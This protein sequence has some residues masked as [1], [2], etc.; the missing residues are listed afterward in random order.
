MAVATEE[1]DYGS[2]LRR[3]LATA[4]APAPRSLPDWGGCADPGFDRPGDAVVLLEAPDGRAA[5]VE[6]CAREAAALVGSAIE[7]GRGLAVAAAVECARGARGAILT[8]DPLPEGEAPVSAL[9]RPR[10]AGVL[11][12][13]PKE[14]LP[15]LE[16]LAARHGVAAVCLGMVGGDRLMFCAT[17][18]ILLEIATTELAPRWLQEEI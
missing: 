9:F 10:G 12:S 11:V 2:R 17:T 7:C 18:E 5:G 3:L 6:A 15:D 16:A 14:R 1:Q 4:D 8:L 13:L